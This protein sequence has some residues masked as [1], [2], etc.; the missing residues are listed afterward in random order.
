MSFGGGGQILS[1]LVEAIITTAIGIVIVFLSG[2]AYFA[3]YGRNVLNKIERAFA[4]GYDAAFDRAHYARKDDVRR[5][6]QA[7]SDS[8]EFP[9][10]KHMRRKEQEYIDRIIQGKEPGLYFMLLGPKGSGKTSMILNAM[11]NVRGDGVTVCE[12]HPDLEIFRM[13][14]GKALN[15]Q[16]FEDSQTIVFQRRPPRDGGPGLDIERALNKLEIV[17][18]RYSQ[19]KNRPLVLVLSNIQLCK[20]VKDSQ[21]LLTQIQQRAEL[22]AASRILTVVFS[23]DDFWP[24]LHMRGTASRMHV[25]SVWDL[26]STEAAQAI[27]RLRQAVKRIIPESHELSQVI[28]LMGGRLAHLNKVAHAADMLGMAHRLVQ[29]EKAWLLTLIGL[30]P[31]CDGGALEDQKWS[32]HSWVLLQEFVRMRRDAEKQRL[33]AVE[34]GVWSSDESMLPLPSISYYVCRQIM[35]RADF[36]E[37]L[38]QSNI[39]AINVFHDVLPESELLLNAAREVVEED[40]FDELLDRVWERVGSAKGASQGSDEEKTGIEASKRSTAY[41]VPV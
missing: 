40:G 32:V 7:F 6:S 31:E 4:P 3:W 36:L 9:W 29:A 11:Q 5:L 34:S 1:N 26:N 2:A 33:E 12:M 24:F 13:R 35:T 18:L 30:I 21:R 16:Y 38:D 20:N 14:L 22:W 8:A 15:F 39:V 23:T 28:A 41:I 25:L 17:A 37:R 10:T 19:R 27:V